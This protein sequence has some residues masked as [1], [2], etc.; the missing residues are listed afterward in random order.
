LNRFAELSQTTQIRLA[1]NAVRLS[2]FSAGWTDEH[3]LS[4]PLTGAIFDILV[5][6]FHELL[7]E[8]R[9]IG[10]GLEDLADRVQRMA[11]HEHLIQNGFDRA[12]AADPAG[13]RE[14]FVDARDL[15]GRYIAE[16][17]RRLAPDFLTYEE[18]GATLVAVDRELSGSRY[19]RVILVNFRWR[20]IGEVRVGPWLASGTTV[21]HLRSA[22]TMLPEDQTAARRISYRERFL[23]ARSGV[24]T[25]VP[26]SV[27]RCVAIR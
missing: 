9:L 27:R 23:L 12:Y 18:I 24:H 14:A 20:G 17:W 15:V 8:R 25:G 22:R 5:D 21:S 4:L 19:R 6:I 2:D 11:E 1:S 10:P 7:V 26:R 3:D 16:S 13:F